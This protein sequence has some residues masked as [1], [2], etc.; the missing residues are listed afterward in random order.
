ME[1]KPI[2]SNQAAFVKS[3]TDNASITTDELNKKLNIFYKIDWLFQL[4]QKRYVLSFYAFF[5]FFVAFMMRANLSVAI[6]DMGKIILMKQDLENA[7]NIT[8][9]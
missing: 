4:I 8:V 9:S 6:V 1:S 5:G 3:N 7:S 2:L